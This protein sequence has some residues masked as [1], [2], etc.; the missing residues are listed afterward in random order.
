V[1]LRLLALTCDQDA[2]AT[3]DVH[4]GFQRATEPANV[5]LHEIQGKPVRA[6]PGGGGDRHRYER[7]G[8]RREPFRERRPQSVAAPVPAIRD[9]D[10]EAAGAPRWPD[11]VAL[12][13]HTDVD[14]A[15]LP[16]RHGRHLL[17]KRELC[18]IAGLAGLGPIPERIDVTGVD[19]LDVLSRRRHR[20]RFECSGDR[21][22][23]LRWNRRQPHIRAKL[24][25][26]VREIEREAGQ[27][28]PRLDLLVCTGLCL[29]SA[30]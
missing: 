24:G 21:G 17:G 6:R 12:I 18:A 9:G 28:P 30:A 2:R 14:H 3:N 16:G 13:A 25:N 5:L 4:I 19:R 26:V 15:H 20:P 22:R 23:I 1:A 27:A 11:A 29:A 7:L 8:S 10:R